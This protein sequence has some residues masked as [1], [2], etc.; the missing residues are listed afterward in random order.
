MST[1]I[2]LRDKL[3]KRCLVTWKTVQVQCDW[4]YNAT[5]ISINGE[6][7]L[8]CNSVVSAHEVERKAQYWLDGNHHPSQYQN[9]QKFQYL[10]V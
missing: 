8:L 2:V 1:S 5:E 9:S 7:L 10:A 6:G 4:V 3:N